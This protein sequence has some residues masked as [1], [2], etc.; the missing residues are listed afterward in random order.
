M[1]L[2]P[3]SLGEVIPCRGANA[4][5]HFAILEHLPNGVTNCGRLG[6]AETTVDT[7]EVR[8]VLDDIKDRLK[9]ITAA[10]A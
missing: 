7:L 1:L 2:R 3:P 10:R 9:A 5:R 6:K 4:A 8:P